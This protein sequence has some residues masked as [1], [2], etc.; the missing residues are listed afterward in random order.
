M[1]DVAHQMG[2]K[3]EKTKIII[4]GNAPKKNTTM[5]KSED[6]KGDWEA[7]QEKIKE[8]NKNLTKLDKDYAKF[9][10][11]HEVIVRMYH[12]EEKYS[13]AG[14]ITEVGDIS[15]GQKA[16]GGTI[17]A[18]HSYVTSPWRYQTKCVVVSV[19]EHIQNVK[20]GDIIQIKNE[21]I[22]P[23]K[24]T[25]SDFILPLAFTLAEHYSI[26]PP[27]NISDKHFGYMR[28]NFFNHALGRIKS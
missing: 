8:Y 19:P 21:C 14:I 18:I 24:D 7:Q 26:T 2:K 1:Q 4:P 16:A 11:F 10:P 15:V 22:I 3:N 23:V 6:K 12:R 27:K 13:D 28:I 17:D 5:E 20:P 9:Q 25:Q